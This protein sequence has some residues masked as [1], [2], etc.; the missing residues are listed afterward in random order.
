MTA[1]RRNNPR[2]GVPMPHHYER[3]C[4]RGCWRRWS[5]ILTTA[6]T[7]KRRLAAL[8]WARR[9]RIWRS[10][11]R[12]Q[13]L[14]P[15]STA[16]GCLLSS[17]ARWRE[18]PHPRRTLRPS[19]H[20]TPNGRRHTRRLQPAPLPVAHYTIGSPNKR[21]A[22][23]TTQSVSLTSLIWMPHA[24]AGPR[25]GGVREGRR[26]KAK[27]GHRGRVAKAQTK[28]AEVHRGRSDLLEEDR[29]SS[30]CHNPCCLSRFCAV[31]D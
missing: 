15:P 19:A 12:W 18:I 2:A 24:A 8:S 10:C 5:C 22:R 6:R 30:R 21:N 13:R 1:R 9:G 17:G 4:N 29:A 3:S 20:A 26:R 14:T 25:S 23:E 27:R 16:G 31:G 11:G 28:D 7:A